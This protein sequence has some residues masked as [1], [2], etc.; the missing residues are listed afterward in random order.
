MSIHLP[1]NQYRGVNAHL[2]SF[3]QNEPGEWWNSFHVEFIVEVRASVDGY[4]PEPY[5]AL[6]A[7]SIQIIDTETSMP[8]EGLNSVVIYRCED[9]GDLTPVTR[10]ELLTPDIKQMGRYHQDYLERRVET[11]RAGINLVEIDFL[12]QTPPPIRL[13]P[14]Y[15]HGEPG[16]YAYSIWV[17]RVHPTLTEGLTSI[18]GFAVDNPIPEVIIPLAGRETIDFDFGVVYDRTFARNRYYGAVV[19]DYAKMP[20]RFETY[21]V[22][23]QARIR[24]RMTAVRD[25]LSAAPK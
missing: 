25:G 10:L 3:L 2:H 13:E 18:Y 21:N 23:D 22:N 24:A 15:P 1:E 8:D 5:Y 16:S 11:L 4:L 6:A 7:P 14:S 20:E 9:A 12:H 17:S 19:V